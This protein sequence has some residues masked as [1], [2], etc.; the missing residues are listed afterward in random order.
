MKLTD[1]LDL[2]L[3]ETGN[4]CYLRSYSPKFELNV[5]AEIHKE[6]DEYKEKVLRVNL[7][8]LVSQRFVKAKEKIKKLIHECLPFLKDSTTSFD[9]SGM[10]FSV[11]L[12]FG[13]TIKVELFISLFSVEEEGFFQAFGDQLFLK[14]HRLKFRFE[15]FIDDLFLAHEKL[16]IS[17]SQLE[18]FWKHLTCFD[19]TMIPLNFHN[20]T[21]ST[22]DVKRDMQ[23][24][25][26]KFLSE[27]KY[28]VSHCF[29]NR[30][31]LLFL[32]RGSYHVFDP[33]QSFPNLPEILLLFTHKKPH[34]RNLFFRFYLTHI[35][36]GKFVLE[37]EELPKELVSLILG[38]F[39]FY[40]K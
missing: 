28:V 8:G 21:K 11:T 2:R 27:S 14:M 25:L 1:F 7:E 6:F 22:I 40:E 34:Y 15:E 23:I 29:T 13:N 5:D 18:T 19:N 39:I 30:D 33:S 24:K 20:C 17:F 16:G 36:L 31:K 26:F 35:T 9:S 38:K 4:K 32:E 12:F 3:N 10:V 37:E